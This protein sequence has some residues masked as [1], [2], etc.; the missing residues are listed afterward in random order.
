VP[1]I[2]RVGKARVMIHFNDHPPAHV[3]ITAAG[4]R[5]VILIDP[6][7]GVRESR[8]FSRTELREIADKVTDYSDLLTQRWNS[9]HGKQGCD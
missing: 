5:A 2:F 4:K 7:V 6:E 9:I 8:G 1:T 3:H